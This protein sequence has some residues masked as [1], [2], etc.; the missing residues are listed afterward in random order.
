VWAVGDAADGGDDAAAVGRLV[1]RGSPDRFLYLGDVYE[2]GT[3]EEFREHYAPAFGRLDRITAPTPGNHEAAQHAQGYD[4]YWRKAL[5]KRPP[6]YYSFEAGGWRIISLNSEGPRERGGE[7]E[8]WL[9]EQAA[10]PGTCKLAFWHRPR[11][12]AGR[13]HGDQPD[14]QPF[15][16]ALAGRAALVVNGHEHDMQRFQPVRGI[17][18]LVSGAGG[19]GHYPVN[20]DDRRL[21]FSNDEEYGALRIELR[22]GEARYAFVSVRGRELDSG[23]VRCRP[24]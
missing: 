21:A 19:H 12:S 13:V 10:A 14:V 23:R 15:W 11:Y 3:A 18:E 9:R 2:H 17:T 16:D 7:Q 22:R 6:G 24:G 5:G 1:A 20:E 8:R 4:P